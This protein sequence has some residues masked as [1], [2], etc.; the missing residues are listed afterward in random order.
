[1]VAVR[2]AAHTLLPEDNLAALVPPFVTLFYEHFKCS[3]FEMCFYLI[4]AH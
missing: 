3:V 1:M 4:H 2:A